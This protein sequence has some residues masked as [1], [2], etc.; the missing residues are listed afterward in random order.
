MPDAF[1][2]IIKSMIMAMGIALVLVILW[3]RFGGGD[4]LK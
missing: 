3:K 2:E 1:Q 4:R